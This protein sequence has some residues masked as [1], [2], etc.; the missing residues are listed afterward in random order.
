MASAW[1]S[2]YACSAIRSNSGSRISSSVRLLIWDAGLDGL[3][4]RF[5][6]GDTCTIDMV[7]LALYITGMGQCVNL[8]CCRDVQVPGRK[9]CYACQRYFWRYKK[10]RQP[11]PTGRVASEMVLEKQPSWKGASASQ[12]AQRR[13]I[14]RR[15]PLGQCQRCDAIAIDRHH[16]NGDTNDND[17]QNILCLCRRCHMLEDGR[18]EAL[19]VMQKV[20]SSNMKKPPRPCHTCAKL[21]T[22]FWYGECHACN[23]Y[24]RRTG[25]QRPRPLFQGRKVASSIR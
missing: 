10:E 20:V 25:H 8:H 12:V 21:V 2:S 9:R 15:L 17:I 13:R 18:L 19:Q 5:P 16:I 3:A 4:S 23:E 24:R 11:G 14:Q 22:M 6:H 7:W 1:T